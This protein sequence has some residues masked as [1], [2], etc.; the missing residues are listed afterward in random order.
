MVNGPLAKTFVFL[1][2]DLVKEI[3]FSLSGNKKL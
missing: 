3:E 1:Y 2:Q